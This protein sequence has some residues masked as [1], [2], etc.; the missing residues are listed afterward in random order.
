MRQP[1]IAVVL[2]GLPDKQ[3]KQRLYLRYS[4]AYQTNYIA[5]PWKLHPK[6]WDRKAQ[7]VKANAI[8]G[9]KGAAVVNM[10][11]RNK[12]NKAFLITAELLASDINPDFTTFRQ[13]FEVNK[14]YF[15]RL[16]AL[17]TEVLENEFSANEITK[18]T[19]RGYSAA[20]NKFIHLVGDLPLQQITHDKIILFKS[21]MVAQGKENLGAQYIRNLSAVHSKITKH[22]R[23][24]NLQNPFEYIEVK[25]ERISDKKQLSIKEYWTMRKA[26]NEFPRDSKEYET[27]R[28]F[29][30]MCRGLRY[31]DTQSIEKKKHYFEFEDSG[32]IYRYLLKSAQK[33]G[34]EEIVPIS[35]DDAQ[36]LLR[37]REDGFLFEYSGYS[38]YLHR[39][40]QISNKLIGREITT[41]YGRHFTGDI[42]LKSGLMDVDDAKKILG[43]NSSRIAEIYA[44]K[45]IKNVL[46]R[47]YAALE[48]INE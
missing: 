5:F 38:T 29:L 4:F 30:I 27:L 8:L 36:D 9:G 13:K 32:T 14:T 47:F 15:E 48:T 34:V 2:R 41:H 22:H 21:R 19:M 10:D 6:E 37:W 20:I 46:K 42:M 33:T 1:S 40:K 11:L 18:S 28:R 45:D 35:A 26:L 43:I 7:M 31:S 25:I 39:L 12:L 44:Q 3:G 16:G 24:T 17:A 23:L